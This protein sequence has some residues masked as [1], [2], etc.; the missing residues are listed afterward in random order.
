MKHMKAHLERPRDQAECVAYLRVSRERQG[1]SG[2]GIEAQRETVN[3]FADAHGFE[4]V[5]EFIA[6][7]TGKGFDALEHRPRLKAALAE[8]MK[9]KCAIVVAKLDRLSRDVAFIAT[10]MTQKVP[11]IVAELG[12]D[13]DPFTLQTYAAVA[14]KE[15]RMIARRTKD[16]LQSAKASGT[17]LGSPT[18][19]HLH[20]REANVRAEGFRD[21]LTPMVLAGCSAREIAE[22]LNERGICT[23]RGSKWHSKTIL[24]V[25]RRLGIEGVPDHLE[26]VMKVTAVPDTFLGGEAYDPFPTEE[27]V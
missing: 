15:R 24:R 3:R 26:Q 11:F 17:K 9:L 13:V 12:P 23:S 20:R 6:V 10:L 4:V 2:L 18:S 19:H 25:I 7:E 27:K 8:A 21:L 5:R 22:K 1:R 14:E 16:S